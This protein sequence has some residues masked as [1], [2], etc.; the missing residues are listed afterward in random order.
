MFFEY[1]PLKI[2]LVVSCPLS[3]FWRSP[4]KEP[5]LVDTEGFS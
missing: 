2:V 5:C 3:G 1:Q 4:S